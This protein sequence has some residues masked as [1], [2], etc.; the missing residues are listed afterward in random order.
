MAHWKD[1]K[2][3]YEAKVDGLIDEIKVTNAHIKSIIERNELLE[4]QV[5]KLIVIM[6]RRM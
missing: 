6:Y 3:T 5:H 1:T 2:A 4:T